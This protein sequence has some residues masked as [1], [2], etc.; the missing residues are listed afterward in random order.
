MSTTALERSA[1]CHYLEPQQFN[2]MVQIRKTTTYVLQAHDC[3]EV[4]GH[5]VT[6]PDMSLTIDEILTNHSRGIPMPELIPVYYGEDDYL[7]NPNTLDLTEKEDLLLEI[8]N[9]KQDHYDKL[10][11]ERKKSAK[12]AFE[13]SL[14]EEIDKR[15]KKA[16]PKTTGDSS[17]PV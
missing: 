14:Q 17:D 10:E 5:S 6:V 1:K 3:E 7:P 16:D 2:I 12:L 8:A 11:E 15:S 9:T 4:L 13:K